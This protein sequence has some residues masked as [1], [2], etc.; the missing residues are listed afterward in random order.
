MTV[1]APGLSPHHTASACNAV[2]AFIDASVNSE[3][4][5]TKKLGQSSLVWQALFDVFMTRFEDVKPKPLKQVLGSLAAILA[6]H[7]EGKI[8]EA[9]NKAVIDSILPSIVLGEPRSRLK[10]SL[11]C[12]ELFIRK[13]AILPSEL[14]PLVQRW[15]SKNKS[16]WIPL[17]EKDR[18]TLFPD[19]ACPET[20]VMHDDPSEELAARVFFLGLLDQTSNRAMAGTSGMMLATFLRRLKSQSPNT[21]LSSLWVSPMRHVLLKKLDSLDILSV[22]LL[23]PLFTADPPGFIAFIESLPLINLST[24]NMSGAE[25]SEYMLLF[26]SL[27]VGKKANLVHEDCEL[28]ELRNTVQNL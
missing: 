5:E 20:I 4:P 13:S 28:S 10:G 24:G 17:F 9:S 16:K 21:K 6:K 7:H 12:L 22:Q 23:T 3:N 2:S 19:A 15:L 26:A 14:I 8:R 27:E 18:H 1:S 11:V 25:Q